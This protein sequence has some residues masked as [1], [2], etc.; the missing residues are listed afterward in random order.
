MLIR[1]TRQLFAHARD[2]RRWR[3][4]PKSAWK[5]HRRDCGGSWS[6]PGIDSATLAATEWLLCAQKH[7]RSSDGG[8]ACYFSLI[9]GW[10]DSY[11][12][13][14]GYI[15]P[16]M[17]AQAD[18]LRN[19]EYAAS[20]RQ[21]LDWLLRIQLPC[22]GFQ[23]GVISDVPVVPVVFNTGQ[24]LIGLAAGAARIGD[25][26]RAAMTRA[27]DWLSDC[28]DTD[29]CWRRNASPFARSGEKTYDTHTAWGLLEAA[30]ASQSERHADAALR[31]IH[32][33]LGKMHANGWFQDCC[34]TDPSQ[35]LTHTL[36][37]ALRGIIEGYRFSTD[38]RLLEAAITSAN[39]LL[40][41]QRDDGWMPGRLD[42]HLRGTVP[43]T[44]LTGNVQIAHCWL[45]LFQITSD[46]RYAD[47]A[48]AANEYVRRTVDVNGPA[49]TAG[50]IRGSFPVSGEYGPFRYLNWAA[51]FFVDSNMLEQ[52]L[53]GS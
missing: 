11:P 30:R 15:V 9:D 19:V 28:Q 31:N 20:A 37:Y 38:E 2:L 33:A 3:T 52:E 12:E 41:T 50:A 46:G 14:T 10:G 29:G 42:H 48:C 43:W 18:R 22:G 53:L 51:K 34:L 7:S 1:V 35:P 36:G 39:G 45:Q 32:W 47:A 4:L 44:C 25:P 49:E 23:G 21:M 6:D 5:A 27:A 16:T 40:T 24:I 17:F 13:T 8:V 26:Y